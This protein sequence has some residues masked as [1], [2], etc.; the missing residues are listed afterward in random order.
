MNPTID[1]TGRGSAISGLSLLNILIGIWFF[2]SPWVF[3]ASENAN[4]WNA[5]IVGAVIVLFAGLRAM[6]GGGLKLLGWLNMA[7]GIWIFASPW[8]FGYVGNTGRLVNSLFVGVVVVL[9]SIS[10]WSAQPRDIMPHRP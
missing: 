5:W 9:L 8:I 2:I 4:A 3:G 1:R 6:N 7:P 10:P